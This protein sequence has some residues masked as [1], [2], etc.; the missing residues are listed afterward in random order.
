MVSLRSS[1]TSQGDACVKAVWSSSGYSLSVVIAQSRSYRMDPFAGMQPGSATAPGFDPTT[2]KILY[3]IV[4]I[5]VIE[6][7]DINE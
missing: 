4:I 3:V 6:T 2:Q 7:V 5:I 1:M